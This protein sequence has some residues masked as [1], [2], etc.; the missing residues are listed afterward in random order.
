[1]CHFL[2]PSFLFPLCH[3]TPQHLDITDQP[4]DDFILLADA[5]SQA[6]DAT[7][8][9]VGYWESSRSQATEWLPTELTQGLAL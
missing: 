5:V 1:M 9:G 2:L 7:G 8:L 3:D 6:H 4:P